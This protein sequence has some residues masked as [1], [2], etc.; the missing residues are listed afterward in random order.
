MKRDVLLIGCLLIVTVAW[1]LLLFGCRPSDPVTVEEDDD[2]DSTCQVEAGI[3][4]AE[5]IRFYD[6]CNTD[7]A[8]MHILPDA[9][10]GLEGADMVQVYADFEGVYRYDLVSCETYQWHMQWIVG[11][12]VV[13]SIARVIAEPDPYGGGVKVVTLWPPEGCPE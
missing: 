3:P 4:Y 6:G 12:K 9:W 5:E 2:T 10:Y 7:P 8:P 11:G 1:V 13:D